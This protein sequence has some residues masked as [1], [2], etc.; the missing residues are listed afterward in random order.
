M[1]RS[2]AHAWVH[3]VLVGY[4][5]A[6]SLLLLREG[7]IAYEAE[8]SIVRAKTIVM[9]LSAL[10]TVGLLRLPARHARYKAR[11]VVLTLSTGVA[12]Y[13]GD[14]LLYLQEV[15]ARQHPNLTAARQ[16]GREY[17][18]RSPLQVLQDLRAR[19]EPAFPWFSAYYL[20]RRDRDWNL[21]IGGE[22]LFPFGSISRTKSVFCNENGEYVA[23]DTDEHGFHNPKGAYDAPIDIVAIGDSFT[24]GACVRS[25]R[26]M[27]SKIREHFPK[28]LNLGKSGLGPLAE[29]GVIREY[30]V[31]LRPK[32]VLLFY[33][34]GNDLQD[35]LGEKQSAV[36]MKYLDP[37]FSQRLIER[38]AQ[39][40]AELTRELETVVRDR[41]LLQTIRVPN[42]GD[43]DAFFFN[44]LF[45]R[46]IQ[47]AVSRV[48]PE[49][50]SPPIKFDDVKDL[51]RQ[52]LS[53]ANESVTSYGGRLYLVYLPDWEAIEFKDDPDHVNVYRTPANVRGPVLDLVKQ[54]G[55]PVIDLQDTFLASKDPLSLFTFRINNHYNENGYQ[56]V[57][58]T[59]VQRL[60]AD[61]ITP[62]H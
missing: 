1:Q 34:A 36:L 59:V 26:N 8:I 43:G 22:L 61:G 51:F 60:R 6:L 35:L 50:Q 41:S 2:R 33:Y 30:A 21:S 49:P 4:V 15:R 12:L 19:G 53:V 32:I 39:I 14:F 47:H 55:I 62:V 18:L 5:I 44:V 10:L 40:D 29:L 20:T 24:E 25:E 48:Q 13:V 11:F 56:L 16:L 42:P 58:D 28:T 46:H 54:I 23:Y 3:A 57:A 52:V 37:S 27:V 38:Q 17:D 9:C 45:L 31:P 7:L